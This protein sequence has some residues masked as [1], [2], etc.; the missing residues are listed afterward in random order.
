MAPGEIHSPFSTYGPNDPYSGAAKAGHSIPLVFDLAAAAV[1][2]QSLGEAVLAAAAVGV[3]GGWYRVSDGVLGPGQALARMIELSGAPSPHTVT[4]D[5]VAGRHLFN[6]LVGT[7]ALDLDLLAIHGDGL[8]SSLG[9]AR[10]L[11]SVQQAALA[12]SLWWAGPAVRRAADRMV[13]Q[14]NA[15][16]AGSL[17]R[18]VSSQM[19][20]E[21]LAIVLAMG[22][23]RSD[24]SLVRL[25]TSLATDYPWL[26]GQIDLVVSPADRSARLNAAVADQLQAIRASRYDVRSSM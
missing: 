13:H 26:A 19:A 18:A 5:Q 21:L 9:V 7:A 17:L 24:E 15:S 16:T 23:D 2:G 4:W 3:V 6:V 11:R 8:D 12:G 14:L 1:S 20:P 22:I 25:Q 10:S